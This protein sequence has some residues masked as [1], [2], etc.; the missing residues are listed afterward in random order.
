MIHILPRVSPWLR[1]VH[2]GAN[3][4]LYTSTKA[5]RQGFH[6]FRTTIILGRESR[7]LPDTIA[8]VGGTH[9]LSRLDVFFVLSKS[10]CCNFQNRTSECSYGLYP[11]E[12]VNIARFLLHT[13][14]VLK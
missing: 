12:I 2:P 10:D 7:A 6:S 14:P 5:T 3:G 11:Y 13:E 8:F 1:K 9:K 4:L